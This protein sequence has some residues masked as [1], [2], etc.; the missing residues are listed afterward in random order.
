MIVE[1]P[2]R[3]LQPASSTQLMR[4]RFIRMKRPGFLV[5]NLPRDL[6]ATAALTLS[7]GTGGAGR[8]AALKHVVHKFLVDERT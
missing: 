3:N 5:S 8:H 1:A 4:R 2:S 7:D 6:R